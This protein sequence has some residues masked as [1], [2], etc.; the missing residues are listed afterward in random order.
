MEAR[1]LQFGVP[2]TPGT[3]ILCGQ[4]LNSARPHYLGVH[5]QNFC[6]TDAGTRLN[7]IAAHG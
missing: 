3:S 2:C 4:H 7:G 5:P 1:W 6:V